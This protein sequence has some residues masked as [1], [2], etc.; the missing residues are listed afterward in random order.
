MQGLLL[1]GTQLATTNASSRPRLTSATMTGRPPN[2]S[3]G[4]IAP[5]YPLGANDTIR[6]T[7]QAWPQMRPYQGLPTLPQ[8]NLTQV[9][10]VT[11][12]TS[13]AQQSTP[14]RTSHY[15][16]PPPD[17]R[18]VGQTPSVEPIG[19]RQSPAEALRQHERYL[20]SLWTSRYPY[21]VAVEDRVNDQEFLW[22]LSYRGNLAMGAREWQTGVVWSLEEYKRSEECWRDYI[23]SR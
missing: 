20:A 8:P 1:C 22:W 23:N 6:V 7:P 18:S 13:Q 2:P 17:P 4:F 19:S 14:A 12:L 15:M 3:Q 16:P 21:Y 9:P 10:R 11:P 5:Q